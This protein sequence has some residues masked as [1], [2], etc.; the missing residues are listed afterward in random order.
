T[1]TPVIPDYSRYYMLLVGVLLLIAILIAIR[2]PR[3]QIV[4]IIESHTQW[5]RRTGEQNTDNNKQK[6]LPKQNDA[7]YT[8]WY[9]EAD[10]EQASLDTEYLDGA[11]VILGRSSSLANLVLDNDSISR[12]H[13][14]IWREGGKKSACLWIEDLNAANGVS[15]N[16]KKLI[17]YQSHKLH[18]GCHIVIGEVELCLQKNKQRRS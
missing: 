14:R 13:A 12:R 4:Q 16:E 3:E 9:L 2:K 15:V 10:G 1:Q 6:E 17:A 11:G 18:A 7:Q 5:L 8:D